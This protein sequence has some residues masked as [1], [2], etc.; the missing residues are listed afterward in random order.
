[1]TPEG[2]QRLRDHQ[3]HVSKELKELIPKLQYMKDKHPVAMG[4]EYN[5]FKPFTKKNKV[6]LDIKRDKKG[7]VVYTPITSVKKE[8]LLYMGYDKKEIDALGKITHDEAIQGRERLV[9]ILLEAGIDD[10]ASEAIAVLPKWSSVSKLYGDKPVILGL[11]R[12]EEFRM[13]TNPIDASIGTAGMF[14]TG[15]NPMSMYISNNMKMPNNRKDRAGG[16]R[17]QVPWGKH[18]LASEK[19]TNT[20]G[21]DAKVNKTNVLP[22]VMVRDPYNWMQSMCR[23]N[24]EARWPHR[25][26][27]PNLAKPKLQ[28]DG[29]ARKTPMMLKYKPPIYF[30]SLADYWG[31]WYKEYLEAD[32]PRLIVRFEDIQFH[33]KE[34]I[35]VIGQC[36]GAVPRE[37]D[38]LFRYVVDSAKWGAAHQSKSNMISA[39]VKYGT[40]KNRFNGMTEADW[41]VAKE[42]FTPELMELFGYEM[43][44]KLR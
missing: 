16:T 4:S 23:H 43:P 37:D 25:K 1:L 7:N 20:A 6:Q 40:D 29:T 10:I 11:E 22:V 28:N 31:Q 18:R 32:Y 38:E 17:W 44:E 42:V 35:E 19:L 26:E 3:N 30:D 12:C 36:A 24:Y 33:A 15:T 5:L 14:N 41:V 34:L 8:D 39:M 9:D 13:Q 2:Q 27:C 21:H